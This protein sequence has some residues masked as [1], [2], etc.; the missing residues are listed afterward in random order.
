MINMIINQNI[1]IVFHMC[2]S[3][4]TG[5]TICRP[6]CILRAELRA[7]WT[8]YAQEV[9][10]AEMNEWV[11]EWVAS[12]VSR[13]IGP[14][15]IAL[16]RWAILYTCTWWLGHLSLGTADPNELWHITHSWRQE[17]KEFGDGAPWAAT[18]SPGQGLGHYHQT[19]QAVEMGHWC[20]LLF[21]FSLEG[22]TSITEQSQY[23]PMPCYLL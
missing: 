20:L 5:S 4:L 10:V 6:S 16:H 1:H 2:S 23:P 3:G 8:A 21:Y 18:W 7:W 12:H 13:P 22:S 17:G 15:L 14:G 19:S 11:S 9:F